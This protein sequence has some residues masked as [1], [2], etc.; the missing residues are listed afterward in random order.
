MEEAR[1]TVSVSTLHVT[2]TI[3]EEVQQD[4]VGLA[5][6]GVD[7]NWA[8]AAA[9]AAGTD[10]GQVT[11]AVGAGGAVAGEGSEAGQSWNWPWLSGQGTSEHGAIDPNALLDDESEGEFAH[12]EASPTCRL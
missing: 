7:P 11:A 2:S 1:S 6:Q 8:D 10:W 5:K 12:P 4:V 3:A 9:A